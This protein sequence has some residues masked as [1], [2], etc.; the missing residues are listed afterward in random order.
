MSLR[1]LHAP[2]FPA[3]VRRPRWRFSSAMKLVRR[4]HLYSG[5]ALVPF[6]VLYGVTAWLFNHPGVGAE[7]Q[8]RT[9]PAAELDAQGRRSLPLPLELAQQVLEGVGEPS[10]TLDPRS[11]VRYRGRL[12]L[13]G[14]T[15]DLDHA[16]SI[17]EPNGSARWTERPRAARGEPERRAIELPV[18]REALASATE[19]ALAAMRTA[20]PAP[21]ELRVRSAPV[22]ELGLLAD[23]EKRRAS[24]D[25]AKGELV[26]HPAGAEPARSLRSFLLRLHTAHGYPAELGPRTAWALL[27]DLMAAALVIW[28]LSGLLMWWQMKLLRRAGLLALGAGALAALVLGERMWGVLA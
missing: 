8:A 24:Y 12:A 6:V 17:D 27:V 9:L 26:V 10:W 3:L 18:V 5:L 21:S 22:L 28:A 25:L 16:L 11:D 15:A 19:A 1:L 13:Q 23:G 20:G 2:P 4:F 7:G 14:R